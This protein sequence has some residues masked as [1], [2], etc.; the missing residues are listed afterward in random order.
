MCVFY[1]QM[2]IHGKIRD[3][4]AE[5]VREDLDPGRSSL[6]EEDILL[7]LQRRGIVDDVMKDLH[8]S[9]VNYGK[10]FPGSDETFYYPE[11]CEC[12]F[13]RKSRE[14]MNTQK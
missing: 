3:V 9:K 4:L 13:L 6:S 8:F 1:C 12:S 14:D 11:G 2:N 7:A 10:S 5:T